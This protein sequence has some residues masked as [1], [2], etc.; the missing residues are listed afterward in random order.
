MARLLRNK[1][2]LERMRE[3]EIRERDRVYCRHDF[4]H[5]MDV[6]RLGYLYALEEG[7]ALDKE[8]FYLTALLHDIGRIDEYRYGISH[9]EAGKKLAGEILLHIGY[10]AEKIPA[11]LSAIGGHRG[12]VSAGKTEGEILSGLLKR[13]DQ[14]SRPCFACHAADTCKWSVERRNTPE[15]WQ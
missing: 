11:I 9:A 10:P 2:F 12:D 13:A 1:E 7:L 14:K 6:A 3:L 4:S 8:Q 5:S 15:S